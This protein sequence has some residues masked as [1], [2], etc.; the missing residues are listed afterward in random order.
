[1]KLYSCNFEHM[2]MEAGLRSHLQARQSREDRQCFEAAT[3]YPDVDRQKSQLHQ[4]A[5][6]A[7]EH[8]PRDGGR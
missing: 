4:T 5:A 7:A 3:V 8:G 2:D 6:L 1:M